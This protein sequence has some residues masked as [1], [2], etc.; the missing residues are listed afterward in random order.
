[1]T[2]VAGI[3]TSRLDIFEPLEAALTDQT[4]F[5]APFVPSYTIESQHDYACRLHCA[6]RSWHRFCNPAA[7]RR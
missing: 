7:S 2:D 6:F 1:M 5:E 4:L 3:E